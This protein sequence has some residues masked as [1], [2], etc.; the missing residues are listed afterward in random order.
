MR[1]F[2]SL[3][4]FFLLKNCSAQNKTEHLFITKDYKQT[5]SI[6]AF[7]KKSIHSYGNKGHGAIVNLKYTILPSTH[8]ESIWYSDFWKNERKTDSVFN[9]NGTLKQVRN[10]DYGVLYETI[11]YDSNGLFQSKKK[12]F[13][14]TA[15]FEFY[16][17]E[18]KV[19]ANTFMGFDPTYAQ[20]TK[21]ASAS[22]MISVLTYPKIAK[23]NRIEG[24]V[25]VSFTA[26]STGEIN[27]VKI[28]ESPHP[29][30]NQFAA[31]AIRQFPLEPNNLKE[32]TTFTIPLEYSLD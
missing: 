4:L 5:D 3:L 1:L 21:S 27:Q 17:D 15:T 12:S 30:F 31:D 11:D 32:P 28:L 22:Y 7:Y 24:T 14:N 25:Y 20:K 9:K 8:Y 26:D 6:N 10:Y 16:I 29:S 23:Q 13:R 18:V 19:S 2:L